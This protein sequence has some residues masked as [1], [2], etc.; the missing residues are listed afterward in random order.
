MYIAPDSPSLTGHGLSYRVT[1][2]YG[3]LYKESW[4]T[5]I[6]HL[7]KPSCWGVMLYISLYFKCEETLHKVFYKR[8]KFISL[9]VNGKILPGDIKV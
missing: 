9:K 1:P 6:T 5:L 3:Q 8:H 4:L 7:L 2:V